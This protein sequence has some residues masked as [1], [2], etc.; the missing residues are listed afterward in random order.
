MV[1]GEL[2]GPIDLSEAQAFY[3][4]KLTK[5]V[6]ICE[7]EQFVLTAFQIVTPYLK[8]FDKS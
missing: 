5:I 2:L 7:D 6:V 3:I 8:G 1:L 4:H